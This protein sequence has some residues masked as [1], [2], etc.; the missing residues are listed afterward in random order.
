MYHVGIDWADRKHDVAIVDEC[1]A[2]VGKHFTLAN[3][4]AG[5]EQLH[6]QLTRLSEDPRD[7]KLGLETPQHLL[8]DF[9]LERG[10]ALWAIFPGAMKSFRKRYRSSGARDDAFDAFVLADVLRTDTACW[11]PVRLGSELLQEIRFLAHAHHD[12]IAWQTMLTNSLRSTLKA[13]YPAALH[14]FSDVACANAL[15]FLKA[16]PNVAAARTLTQEAL[17]AFF[18]KHRLR[19]AKTVAKIY[20]LLQGP[21]V[22]VS[23]ARLR[24]YEL[25]AQ[26]CLAQLT[27]LAP[28]LEAYRA[29]LHE[30]VEAHPDGAL[31]LSY[32]GVSHVT[33]ARLLALFG[34]DRGRYLHAGELQGLVGTCP[35]TEKTGENC[36]MIYYRRACNKFYRDAVQ[37]LA[38]SSLTTC[39]WAKA[40]YQSHRNRGKSHSHALR[41]LANAHMRVLFAMW[42]NRTAYNENT[43]LAQKARHALVNQKV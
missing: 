37:N 39:A 41:C 32:P 7:F 13:Y 10:Y 35:V 25:K 38:F 31:F 40:F 28:Q 34:E 15:A 18:T 21:H 5:Y 3:N 27:A 4:L 14:F 26:A 23:A 2:S 29:R 12:A 9:L 16:Y 42:R 22:P 43:F 11:R 36:R 20:A 1:G 19:N 8:V 33:A 6:A 30:L 17:A 24:A